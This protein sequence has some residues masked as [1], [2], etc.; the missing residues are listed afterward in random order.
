VAVQNGEGVGSLLGYN[1]VAQDAE[2]VG[3]AVNRI[4]HPTVRQPHHPFDKP[5]VQALS[6]VGGVGCGPSDDGFPSGDG[7]GIG[8]E[9]GSNVTSVFKARL[10]RWNWDGP[11][12]FA[13]SWHVGVGS[14]RRA[15][16]LNDFP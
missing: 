10:L 2:L 8:T 5:G 4:G 11:A 9:S 6:V 16:M 15:S 3:T 13:P 1:P 12:L 7:F 14:S